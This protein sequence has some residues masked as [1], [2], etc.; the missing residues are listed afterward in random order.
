MFIAEYSYRGYESHAERR[1]RKLLLTKKEIS[2]IIGELAKKGSTLVAMRLFFNDRGRAKLL[3]G[4]G[5]GKKLYD[6]R[7]T[8]KERDW[9][10]DKQRIMS[11]ANH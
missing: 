5:R 11:Q 4:L 2:K 1:D 8:I 6:K 3:V 10:R 9:S 7:E